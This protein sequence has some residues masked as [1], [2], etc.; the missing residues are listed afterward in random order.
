MFQSGREIA[1]D[2]IRPVIVESWKRSRAFGVSGEAVDQTL[3][4]AGELAGRIADRQRFYDI[5]IPMMESLYQFTRGSGFM[6]ILSD[7]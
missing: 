3:L 4:T 6:L 7:E 5:A 1:L 2:E